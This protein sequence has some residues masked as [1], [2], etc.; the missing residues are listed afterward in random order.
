MC[1]AEAEA[2]AAA[3][4]S[5]PAAL[6]A[7]YASRA[8]RAR[9]AEY[10]G[11]VPED[12]TTFTAT[13]LAG[14]GGRHGLQLPDGAPV[15]LP[16]SAWPTL[17]ED[18]AD[19]CRS[20]GDTQGT[21]LVFDIDYV[22]H[23]DPSEPYRDPART[24]RRLEPVYTATLEALGSRGV[25][26]LTLATGR[27]YHFVLKVPYGSPLR[28][29]LARLGSHAPDAVH[30]GAGRL[31]EHLAHEVVRRAAPHAE[32]PLTLIDWAPPGA[33]AFVCL[34]TSAYGD[35]VDV[36]SARCAFSGNQKPHLKGLSC[37]A[38]AVAVLP[39]DRERLGE[40]L[41]AR[42]DLGIAREWAAGC[43]TTIP[44]LAEAPAWLAAYE[45]GALARFHRFF[46]ELPVDRDGGV[47]DSLD[48]DALP[49]CV[50]FPLAQPN[51]A[52]LTPGWLRA[53]TLALWAMGWHPQAIVGLVRSRYARTP[54]W[55]DYWRR[56]DAWAR[57]SYYVRVCAGALADGTESWDA[58]CC[59]ALKAAGYCPGPNCGYELARLPRPY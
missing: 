1:P 39:R 29:A 38:P 52:L 16:L 3:T 19:V 21:L 23:A 18:G 4:E 37:A 46:D 45:A 28:A 47:F 7:Y 8:V 22:N 6:A 10:C 54:G 55:G 51:A 44:V 57:A 43:R 13:S 35:P 32:V 53:I 59:A 5:V 48:L 56:N 33:Q 25:R 40:V 24:F 30:E 9:I 27:G 58:F 50:A 17:L 11:G 12:P 26:P 34:D 49:R 42:R 31:L 36:R 15:P 41:A 14:Y 20:L 2:S